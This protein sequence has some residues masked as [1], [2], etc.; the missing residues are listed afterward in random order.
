M[1]ARPGRSIPADA[2]VSCRRTKI[3]QDK[4]GQRRRARI[5]TKVDEVGRETKEK[6][7]KETRDVHPK[8]PTHCVHY[9]NCRKP[10]TAI[11]ASE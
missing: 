1:A 11:S 10:T 8:A 7:N 6:V 4:G 3:T 5:G 2:F 9:P